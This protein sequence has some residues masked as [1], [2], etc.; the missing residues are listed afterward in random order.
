[1]PARWQAGDFVCALESCVVGQGF[2]IRAADAGHFLSNIEVDTDQE[3]Q[4]RNHN[5]LVEPA[6]LD[7][8][9]IQ[10]GIAILVC[11]VNLGRYLR[12]LGFTVLDLVSVQCAKSSA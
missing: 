4:E 2:R 5:R 9:I 1:M 10:A 3:A 12:V 11:Q 7:F 6:F 8:G